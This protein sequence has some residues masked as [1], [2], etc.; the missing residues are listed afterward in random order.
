MAK[1][2]D[3][4]IELELA[5]PDVCDDDGDELR[6]PTP[7]EMALLEAE[8]D[9]PVELTMSGFEKKPAALPQPD[10]A[11]SSPDLP[12]VKSNAFKRFIS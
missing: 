12:R 6:E 5:D 4:D 10:R 9:E 1:P 8:E 11:R 7:E 2:S 3:D